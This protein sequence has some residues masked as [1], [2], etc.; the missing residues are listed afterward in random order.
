VLSSGYNRFRNPELEAKTAALQAEFDA[1]LS[2]RVSRPVSPKK[3]GDCRIDCEI[4]NFYA[5][6]DEIKR[7]DKNKRHASPTRRLI[8]QKNSAWEHKKLLLENTAPSQTGY[9]LHYTTEPGRSYLV[10]PEGGQL[11]YSRARKDPIGF[12]EL[13]MQ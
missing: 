9:E 5:V 3:G 10:Q 4:Q 8:N 2:N 13:V 12:Y 7:G 6:M 1:L 11:D